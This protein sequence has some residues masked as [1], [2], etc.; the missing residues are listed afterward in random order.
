MTRLEIESAKEELIEMFHE[1]SRNVQKRINPEILERNNF[2]Q[3]QWDCF[4]NLTKDLELNDDGIGILLDE[5]YA[6]RV[7]LPCDK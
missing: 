2:T 6:G 5:I 1:I 3:E 4:F 7:P